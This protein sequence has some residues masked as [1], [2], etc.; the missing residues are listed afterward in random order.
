MWAAAVPGSSGRGPVADDHR[1]G[2]DVAAPAPPSPAPTRRGE[3][4]SDDGLAFT[5]GVIV[6][7]ET[8]GPD[9]DTRVFAE[10][11]SADS[12]TWSGEDSGTS[13]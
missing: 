3:L 2:G 4:V 10:A 1:F 13:A 12:L 8:A 7:R 9:S 6:S 5:L 11:A